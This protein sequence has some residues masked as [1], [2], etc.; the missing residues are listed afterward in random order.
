MILPL[1][2]TEQQAWT[3]H[4]HDVLYEGD[5]DR[6]LDAL[7]LDMDRLDNSYEMAQ[8]AGDERLA[9][10]AQRLT[11][12]ELSGDW[13]QRELLAL[14]EEHHHTLPEPDPLHTLQHTSALQQALHDLVQHVEQIY[15][16]VDAFQDNWDE[17]FVV[18][19]DDFD[20]HLHHLAKLCQLGLHSPDRAHLN[21]RQ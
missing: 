10:L 12:D 15:T 20:N 1:L 5:I 8:W 3:D 2:T 18:L 11:P 13:N 19:S 21:E 17:E 9:Q 6:F 7:E 16:A 14:I 4:A